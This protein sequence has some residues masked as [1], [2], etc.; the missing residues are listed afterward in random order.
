MLGYQGNTDRAL[1]VF[2]NNSTYYIEDEFHAFFQCSM[3]DDIR[4]Q[5]LPKDLCNSKSLFDF[6]N[7]LERRDCIVIRKISNFIFNMLKN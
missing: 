6:Y 1:T 3:Y 5:Y 2:G 4:Q 7:I